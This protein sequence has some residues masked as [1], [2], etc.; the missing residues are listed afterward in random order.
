MRLAANEIEA[1]FAAW[2]A[3][4]AV[5]LSREIPPSPARDVRV[6]ARQDDATTAV[7]G[8]V[9][10]DSYRVGAGFVEFTA[11]PF[12]AAGR[13]NAATVPEGRS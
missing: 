13:F 10:A 4:V 8:G 11:S 6:Y 7:G 3:I 1:R 12:A 5:A 9:Q 2:P